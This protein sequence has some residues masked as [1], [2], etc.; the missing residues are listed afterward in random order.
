M[1]ARVR[2]GL[3]RCLFGEEELFTAPNKTKRALIYSTVY[4][5]LVSMQGTSSPELTLMEVRRTKV[6]RSRPASS[7]NIFHQSNFNIYSC[8]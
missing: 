3:I 6:L 5:P 8:V 1:N 7:I 2:R 4:L